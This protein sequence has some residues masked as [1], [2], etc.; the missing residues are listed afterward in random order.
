MMATAGSRTPILLGTKKQNQT[1]PAQQQAQALSPASAATGQVTYDKN[2]DY[3]ALMNDLITSAGGEQNLTAEQRGQLAQLEAQRNAKIAG[4]GMTGVNQTYKYTQNPGTSADAGEAKTGSPGVD[5]LK[6]YD[7]SAVDYLKDYDYS[8]GMQ[9]AIAQGDFTRAA[10][11]EQQRNAKIAGENMTGV[12]QTNLWSRYL[13]GTQYDTSDYATGMQQAG[14]D[15]GAARKKLYGL[16]GNHLPQERINSI[17]AGGEGEAA[18]LALEEY[19]DAQARFSQWENDY[20]KAHSATYTQQEYNNLYKKLNAQGADFS[21]LRDQAAQNGNYV[22]AAIYEALRNQKIAEQGLGYDTTDL[23]SSYLS[24][25]DRRSNPYILT[26]SNN[27]AIGTFDYGA[28]KGAAGSSM[29]ELPVIYSELYTGADRAQAQQLVNNFIANGQ[30]DAAQKLQSYIDGGNQAQL[31]AALDQINAY[32]GIGRLDPGVDTAATPA[33]AAWYN[34]FGL[35]TVNVDT[36]PANIPAVYNGATQ[37]GTMTENTMQ[38]LANALGNKIATQNK[39]GTGKTGGKTSGGKFS[40]GLNLGDNDMTLGDYTPLDYD[41]YMSQAMTMEQATAL[42]EQQ[43]A[44]EYDALYAQTTQQIMQNLDRAGVY[45]SVYGQGVL[46]SALNEVN[47]ARQQAV[48]QLATDL[49]NADQAK[50]MSLYETGV[51]ENQFQGSYNMDR[52]N[53]YLDA[54][55]K[56]A[57]MEQDYVLQQQAYALQQQELALET[58]YKNAQ[59]S[60]MEYEQEMAKLAQQ[61]YDAAGGAVND[62]T[63]DNPLRQT[64]YG[65]GLRGTVAS[66]AVNMLYQGYSMEETKNSIDEAVAEGLIGETEGDWIKNYLSAN[67]RQ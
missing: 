10:Q 56:K 38:A 34:R 27:K 26:D 42:A 32:H 47:N 6:D 11:L 60:Q 20:N 61:A 54:A 1:T 63:G 31:Q 9:Q 67:Y 19:L 7:Y 8:A 53:T 25:G 37:T 50:W 24:Y 66:E 36:A 4:T 59:I 18:Q 45:D 5:Y 48:A 23:Y 28:A 13:G 46:Q 41:Q 62:P 52:F 2:T 65:A 40:G 29:L 43:L 22:D 30:Y 39:G 17:L 49:Y 44:A 21:V 57:Q 64:G 33:D 3:S 51:N 58:R 16:V 55:L 14:G 12:N 15:V 35:D